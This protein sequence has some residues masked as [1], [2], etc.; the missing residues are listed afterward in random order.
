MYL[1]HISYLSLTPCFSLPQ[2]FHYKKNKNKQKK[3]LLEMYTLKKKRE[4][5]KKEEEERRKEN[6]WKEKGT[7]F[8]N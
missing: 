2:M 5:E 4:R 1:F 8:E 3:N 7:A 6:V